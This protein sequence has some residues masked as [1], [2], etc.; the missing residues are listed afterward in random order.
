M[1]RASQTVLILIIQFYRRHFTSHRMPACRFYP[2]CSEYA[3]ESIRK[4]GVFRG[5]LRALLRVIRCHPF[6]AGG[7]DPPRQKQEKLL[8]DE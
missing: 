8:I 7:Y 3:I 6:T 1:V 4:N 2:T 5:G